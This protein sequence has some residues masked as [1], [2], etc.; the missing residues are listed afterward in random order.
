MHGWGSGLS[1]AVEGLK[2]QAKKRRECYGLAERKERG[3]K[4]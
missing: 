1:E 3:G 2:I 4:F